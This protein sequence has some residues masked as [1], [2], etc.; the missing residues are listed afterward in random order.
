MTKS[1]FETRSGMSG[2]CFIVDFTQNNIL[3]RATLYRERAAIDATPDVPDQ[4]RVGHG[5]QAKASHSLQSEGSLRARSDWAKAVPAVS[6]LPGRPDKRDDVL[7]C[8]RMSDKADAGSAGMRATV[9]LLA[10]PAGLPTNGPTNLV[11]AEAAR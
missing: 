11:C 8:G 4:I 7:A 6:T 10:S 9:G 2:V 1:P 3:N 5:C